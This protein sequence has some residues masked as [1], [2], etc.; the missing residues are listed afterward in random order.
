MR[1]FIVYDFH[2]DHK[3]SLGAVGGWRREGKIKLREDFV[4]GL[5]NAP[6]AFFGLLR[7]ENFGK[8]VVR[9]SP[10]PSASR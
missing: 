1:G 7:G 6:H 2:D 9:V 10:D 8:L 4:D 5:E 3:E